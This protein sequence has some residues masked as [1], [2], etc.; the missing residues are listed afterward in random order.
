[1]CRARNWV[2][3]ADI[4]ESRC[5]SDG[6]VDLVRSGRS[7][8]ALAP[9]FE[10]SAATVRNWVRQAD[11]DKGR[12]SDGTTTRDREE[13]DRLKRD[14]KRLRL[15]RDIQKARGLVSPGE[16]LGPQTGFGFVRAHRAV[17]P[18]HAM[19]R[20]LGLSMSGYYAWLEQPLSA[21]ARRDDALRVQVRESWEASRRT[22]GRPRI[23]A[24]LEAQGE[25]VAPK[26]IARLMRRKG[27]RARAGGVARRPP[28]CGTPTPAPRPT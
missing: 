26:R 1:M 25:R 4:D 6:M 27:S 23:H 17:F 8:E 9:E 20:V 21:R 22:C 3:Q 12:R 11:I 2:G 10:P 7:P 13:L 24:D 18:V 5:R 14:N 19:C 28:R 16:Q 15:E